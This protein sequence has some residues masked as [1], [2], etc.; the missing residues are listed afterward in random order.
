MK[1]N[2]TKVRNFESFER[3]VSK[4]GVKGNGSTKP[5]NKDDECVLT[6]L[7]NSGSV[8][9]MAEK[10]VSLFFCGDFVVFG[11]L[12]NRQLSTQFLRC[13]EYFLSNYVD[14]GLPLA[15]DVNCKTSERTERT[16]QE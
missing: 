7:Q 2:A 14:D 6:L 11:C 9:N 8:Y 15:S 13:K 3:E 1:A 5:D 4:K 10:T 12:L 16:T